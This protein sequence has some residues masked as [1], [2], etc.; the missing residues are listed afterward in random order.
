MKRHV[1]ESESGITLEVAYSDA[2]NSNGPTLE[3]IHVVDAS[4]QPVGPDLVDFLTNLFMLRTGKD[5]EPEGEQF[6]SIIAG[7][8]SP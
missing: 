2:T 1:H 6:L 3:S 7:E 8:I 5:G 4:Y